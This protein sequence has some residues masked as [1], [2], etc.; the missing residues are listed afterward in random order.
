MALSTYATIEEADVILAGNLLWVGAT[1]ES[2][3][4]ALEMARVYT[5]QNYKINF[6]KS[7]PTEKV[8]Y[9]NSLIAAEHLLKDIFN[10]QTGLGSLEEVTVKASTVTTTKKYTNKISKTWADPFK[11]AT[12][13]MLPD[14]VLK[15]G[16]GIKY[17]QLIRG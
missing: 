17:K 4:D 3:Q 1:T 8:K 6:D 14:C 13:I 7:A 10:R 2:K 15:S 16:S 12:A 5:E 9:G 11:K